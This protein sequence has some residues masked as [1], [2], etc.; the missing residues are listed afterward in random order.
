MLKIINLKRFFSE[1][2]VNNGRQK[3]WDIAKGLAVIFML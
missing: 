3:E 1:K 2:A